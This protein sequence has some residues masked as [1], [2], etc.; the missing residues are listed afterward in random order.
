M[1]SDG[2]STFQT[3]C[4]SSGQWTTSGGECVPKESFPDQPIHEIV[5]DVIMFT[6]HRKERSEYLEVDHIPSH[7]ALG[8]FHLIVLLG[9]IVFIVI[10]DLPGY[11]RDLTKAKRDM[12]SYL[13][14]D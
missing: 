11:K 4:L 13:R 2:G 12:Q 14:R 3:K 5:R 10:V 8:S 6:K 1:V 9:S 7:I